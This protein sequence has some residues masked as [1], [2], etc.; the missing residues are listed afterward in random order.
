MK[1]FQR[2]NTDCESEEFL[3]EKDTVSLANKAFCNRGIPRT[4]RQ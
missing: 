1:H 4:H 3:V 2:P